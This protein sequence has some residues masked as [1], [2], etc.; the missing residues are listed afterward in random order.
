MPISVEQYSLKCKI[1]NIKC[2]GKSKLT[3]HAEDHE[4]LGSKYH[5]EKC[6][7]NFTMKRHLKQHEQTHQNK[8]TF[9]CGKCTKVYSSQIY[10]D[11][12]IFIVHSPIE[13]F[14]E[15]YRTQFKDISNKGVHSKLSTAEKTLKE[16][17]IEAERSSLQR[18]ENNKVDITENVLTANKTSAIGII[19]EHPL[20]GNNIESGSVGK[21]NHQHMERSSLHRI[22]NDKFN[23][24]EHVLTVNKTRKAG[25][26]AENPMKRNNIEANVIDLTVDSVD[27]TN[28]Q[29]MERSSLD[30]SE[31]NK[32][33]TTENVL[34]S[35]KANVIGICASIVASRERRKQS[36]L[37]NIKKL[38]GESRPICR[39]HNLNFCICRL[40][41]N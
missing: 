29:R 30:R 4:K 19:A 35:N 16:N 6:N 15:M 28:N 14:E 2:E 25:I 22:E 3:K 40:V 38:I 34:T 18:I 36:E 10:Y 33:N 11:R 37:H 21:T 39:V 23:I 17:N 27:E 32:F 20:K 7:I 24:T 31:N 26:V 13:K 9:K 5:C 41:N 8:I 12:H 1:C